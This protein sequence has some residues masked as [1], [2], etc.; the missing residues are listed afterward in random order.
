VALITSPFL[1]LAVVGAVACFVAA[2]RSSRSWVRIVCVNAGL[3]L[4]VFGII[5]GMFALLL[6]RRNSGLAQYPA[7]YFH[8]DDDLGGGARHGS[9]RVREYHGKDV[10]YDVTYTIGA[11]GLRVSPRDSAVTSTADCGLFFGDSFTFGEGLADDQ[12]LPYRVGVLSGGRVRV[13]NFGFHGFGPH[14]MLAALERN[15]VAPAINCR[16]TQVVYEA[17]PP[18][19]A[20]AAGLTNVLTHG[21][22][23]EVVPG[24]GGADSVAYRG[25]FDDGRPSRVS[26]VLGVV[27]AKSWIY[28]WLVSLYP[29]PDDDDLRRYLAIV[30][31][32]ARV[33]QAKYPGCRFDVLYWDIHG[34]GAMDERT[35]PALQ[36]LGLRVHVV[37]NI[38]PGFAQNPSQYWLSR[39]DAHPNARADDLLARYLVQTLFS[40]KT[41]RRAR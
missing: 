18:H 13:Y 2:W 34:G 19:V 8:V 11:N 1:W 14:Q 30:A 25:H 22:R 23:Y 20:R 41:E 39:Y 26:A 4:V 29:P 16:P 27:F 31:T 6:T 24:S 15:R 32:S 3:L 28:R 37:E 9:S 36:K 10:V 33:V 21:P 12:T 38:L 35:L 5:E 7:D 40:N 17:I